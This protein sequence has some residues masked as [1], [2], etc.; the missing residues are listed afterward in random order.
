MPGIPASS[1]GALIAG[2][3]QGSAA[4]AAGLAAG[5]TITSLAGH[6]I[7]SASQIRTVLSQYHPGDKVS[8][9]WTDQAGSTHTGSITLAAGPAQ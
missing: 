1:A 5:D 9:S 7:T 8:I 4:A 2:V 6:T 3:T